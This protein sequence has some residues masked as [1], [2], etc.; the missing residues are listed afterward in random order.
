[1]EQGVVINYK[2][3]AYPDKTAVLDLR[4]WKAGGHP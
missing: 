1:M 3:I 2:N 4:T